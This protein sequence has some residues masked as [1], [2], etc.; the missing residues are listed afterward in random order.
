MR[1]LLLLSLL[2][3]FIAPWGHTVPTSAVAAGVTEFHVSFQNS[4][5]NAYSTRKKHR[6]MT[7]GP[8]V[9]RWRR[10]FGQNK[11]TRDE[12]GPE[13]QVAGCKVCNSQ[14]Q[15]FRF[16]RSQQVMMTHCVNNWNDKALLNPLL[17]TVLIAWLPVH[18]SGSPGPGQ[19]LLRLIIT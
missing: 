19:S 13:F 12:P 4:N 5:P 1:L 8:G 3:L 7:S 10:A 9:A 18:Y 2:C 6:R 14:T 16:D 11:K 15:C 17:C